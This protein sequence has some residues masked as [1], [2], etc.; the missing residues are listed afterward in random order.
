MYLVRDPRAIA[1]SRAKIAWCQADP[2]CKDIPN[3]CGAI[4]NDLI[5]LNSLIEKQPEQYYLLKYED[6][7][8]NPDVETGKLFKFLGLEMSSSVRV[9]LESHTR[10]TVRLNDPHSTYRNSN[11]TVSRWRGNLPEK[12]VNIIE[13]ACSSLMKKMNYLLSSDMDQLNAV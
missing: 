2:K 12:Q 6:L 7:S 13:N 1:H 5:L 8:L 10:K 9:F 3:L 4:N 11:L